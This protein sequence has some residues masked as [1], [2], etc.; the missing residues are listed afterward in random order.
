MTRRYVRKAA[1]YKP[2]E[3]CNESNML[4]I[5]N[6]IRCLR[7]KKL[8]KLEQN[9]LRR[10]DELEQLELC[11]YIAQNVVKDFVQMDIGA[12]RTVVAGLK[13][14]SGKVDEK[15]TTEG[16]SHSMRLARVG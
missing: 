2:R 5:M 11:S 13:G 16:G 3:R 9:R 4:W 7:R 12:A 14:S 6:E 15:E 8:D 1:Y 10:E